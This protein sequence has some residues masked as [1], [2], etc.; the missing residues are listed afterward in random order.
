MSKPVPCLICASSHVDVGAV[1]FQDDA[2]IFCLEDQIKDEIRD[3]LNLAEKI[4][5]QFGF[6]KYEVNLSTRPE[7][8]VGDDDVWSKATAALRDALDDEG[9]EY[10]LDDGGGAFYGPKID[11]KIE[12]A[13]GRKWQCSTVDFNLPQRFDIF[14]VDSNVERKRP[15]M[16]HRAILGSLERFFGILIEHYA[17]DFPL[18]ISPIQ[19]RILPVTDT[20]SHGFVLL[21]DESSPTE[22]R[23]SLLITLIAIPPVD[24]RSPPHFAAVRP[25]PVARLP[26]SPAA[27]PALP[28][29]LLC[30]S[31][32]A[33]PSLASRSPAAIPT[34]PLISL[35]L[36]SLLL[37]SL[38]VARL[39]CRHLPISPPLLAAAPPLLCC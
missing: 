4:L 1:P 5:L 32:A 7:K 21:L 14:Y 24:S 3:V 25:S 19:A 2:H 17:G 8:F 13:L 28:P 20:Q 10:K 11:L 15:I 35:P 23:Q 38:P 36:I 30:R 22:R 16:I 31:P 6:E 18:W 34:L 9:W 27:I 26:P 33:R 12:D 29:S 37:I 39:L